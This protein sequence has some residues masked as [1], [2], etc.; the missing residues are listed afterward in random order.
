[1][2]RCFDCLCLQA[3]PVSLG[4]VFN[5]EEW[6]NQLKPLL[7][8]WKSVRR[9]NF[10]LIPIAS[11]CLLELS[12][13]FLPLSHAACAC[14]SA[15]Q[16]TDTSEVLK[17][18]FDAAADEAEPVLAFALKCVLLRRCLMTVCTT[19]S[20]CNV[21]ARSCADAITAAAFQGASVCIRPAT[22]CAWLFRQPF[23]CRARRFAAHAG[24]SERRWRVGSWQGS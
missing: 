8:Y 2:L 20:R 16:I 7:K 12:F 3:V 22:R 10:S 6:A 1:M 24:A 23:R 4:T 17:T 19:G 15:V 9:L 14:A 13:P 11:C 18:R 21:Y 5:R